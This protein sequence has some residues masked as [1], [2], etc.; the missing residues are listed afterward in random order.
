[1]TFDLEPGIVSKPESSVEPTKKY[2]IRFED[3]EIEKELGKGSYGRVC[4]GRW[5]D[6]PV[7]LKFCKEKQALDDF[8][9]EAT[10]MMYAVTLHSINTIHFKHSLTNCQFLTYS[11][12]N[13][14]FTLSN[15]FQI[16]KFH[17]ML[18]LVNCHL[19]HTLFKCMGYQL[20]DHNLFLLWNTVQEVIDHHFHYQKQNS[21]LIE[22][23]QKNIN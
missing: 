22:Q 3:I 13:T 6:T 4:L 15:T 5:N 18:L 17:M 23:Q 12:T 10:L 14:K 19:I 16:V 21:I 7:A 2:Q 1:M 20:M 8:L 11:F 9:K